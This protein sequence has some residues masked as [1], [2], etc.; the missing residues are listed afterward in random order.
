MNISEAGYQ[1]LVSI[2]T[3]NYNQAA[4]TAEF[5]ESSKKLLYPCFEILICDMASTEDPAKIF[6]DVDFPNARLLRCTKN[7]GYAG[8]N[9]WG[10]RQALG[11]YIS[12][13]NNVTDLTPDI[14]Q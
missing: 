4:V 6:R 11:E 8:G 13:V 7:L 9:N 10:I 5:L 1:P 14:I 2:I 12:I 3:L